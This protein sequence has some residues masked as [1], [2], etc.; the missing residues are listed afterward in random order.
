[1]V[2][3]TNLEDR[4]YKLRYRRLQGVV[5]TRTAETVSCEMRTDISD[6]PNSVS[7]LPQKS[8][9]AF[10]LNKVNPERIF[11]KNDIKK[12]CIVYR[13]RFVD[14]HYFRGT[15][16]DEAISQI[17][18]L[19]EQ[20][21]TTLSDFMIVAPAKRLKLENADDPLLF[22]PMGNDYY[23][24]VH[25]WGNDLHPLRK[26][27]MWPYRSFDNLLFTVFIVSLIL[28][29]LTPMHLFTKHVTPQE[30]LLMAFFMFKA[31]GGVVLFYGFA[32]GK[33][34]NSAIWN[35]NYYNA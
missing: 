4:L 32:K 26:W 5:N 25:K 21:Q 27:L 3:R 33:N 29:A 18:Q 9:T 14:A 6:E 23:Y 8:D 2:A 31:V 35:S 1:M 15:F 12:L 20:H 10:I 28:T 13:L 19:E 22:A 11:H 30:Y 16:P 34:F 7:E 24:L 17:K